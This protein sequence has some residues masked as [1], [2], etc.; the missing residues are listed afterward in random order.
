MT[1]AAGFRFSD[2]VLVC[3]D[4][5]ITTPGYMKQSASKIVPI[6]FDSNGGSKALFAITGSVPFAHMAIEHCR[7]SIAAHIPEQMSTADIMISIEDTLQG[8]FE[9]H[10]FKHPHYQ[11]GN[12]TVEMIIAV[13]S[14]IDK[15]LTLLAARENAVTIVRDYECLGAGQFLTNYLLPSIFR[16]SGMN[17]SDT[18]HIALHVLRET[19]NYVDACGGGTEIVVLRK[20]GTFAMAEPIE[21]LSGEQ[22]S[23]A[24]AEA[25][26][27]L[28][29][30]S[31]DMET[32]EDDLH[33]E[34]ETAL[35]IVQ[36]TRRKLIQKYGE[37]MHISESMTK[38]R[39]IILDRK[40]I[41]S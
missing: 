23:E 16:H 39:E 30:V 11:G 27:R 2:G 6:S 33:R 20:D 38:L 26:K 7:R 14:H 24:Y 15:N 41:K 1:I 21:Y 31:A 5:Q 9:D 17:Q 19:K 37:H 12:I 28:F 29:V 10:L 13:W 25:I 40:I 34:F 22:V 18:V 3:A 32:T 35:L 4:T 36:G 8:F